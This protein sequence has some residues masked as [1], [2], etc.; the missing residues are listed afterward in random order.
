MHNQATVRTN[1]KWTGADEETQSTVELSLN[2]LP[3]LGGRHGKLKLLLPIDINKCRPAVFEF[4]NRFA[5]KFQVTAILLHV[6]TL[7]VMAS[8]NRIYEEL[9]AEAE[10][11][12]RR[13]SAKYISPDALVSHRVRIGKAAEL[14]LRLAIDD[15]PDAILMTVDRAPLRGSPLVRKLGL[16]SATVSNTVNS[17]LKSPPCDVLV[18]P[19]T[20]EFDCERAF[21]RLQST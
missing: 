2:G 12:L 8:E 14:I 18:L 15:C 10:S 4:V 9:T 7:N 3:G 19:L 5:R 17:V 11:Y 13:L 21:G 16:S 6:V 1:R 20:G